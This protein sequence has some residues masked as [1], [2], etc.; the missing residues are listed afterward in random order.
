MSVPW[1]LGAM[2]AIVGLAIWLGSRKERD[3]STEESDDDAP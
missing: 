2:L 3:D 1:F